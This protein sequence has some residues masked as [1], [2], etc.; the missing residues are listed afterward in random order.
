MKIY[1]RWEDIPENLK[2]KTSIEKSGRRLAPE[3]QPA[4]QIRRWRRVRRHWDEIIYD[5]YDVTDTV[6]KR[7][8]SQAQAAALE[9]AQA[10]ST[11]S[12]YCASCGRKLD[13]KE[14]RFGCGLC[15]DRNEAQRWAQQLIANSDFVVMDTETTGLDGEIIEVA[16]V[17]SSGRTLLNTRLNPLTEIEPGATAVH[18]LSNADLVHEPRFPQVYEQ[19]KQI[20]ASAGVVIIYNAQFDDARLAQ[21]CKLHGL[22]PIKYKSDCAMLWYAQ[23]YGEWSG[24]WKDYKWQPLVGGDHSALGDC[25][26]TL[27]LLREMAE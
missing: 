7:E 8:M 24:Y 17:D 14:R 22:S 5:L 3:Q 15:R 1:E 19:L 12:W 21:T 18:G 25:L 26:A 2:T 23:F 4:A 10:A 11:A 9:K 16:I 20:L 27:S 6:A 13:R